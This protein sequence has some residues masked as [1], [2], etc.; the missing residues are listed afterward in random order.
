ALACLFLKLPLTTLG[1]S[2]HVSSVIFQSSERG[3]TTYDY[4]NGQLAVHRL[5]H[6]ANHPAGHR[7]ADGESLLLGPASRKPYHT[8]DPRFRL[9]ALH[10]QYGY[11]QS[12][13][14]RGDSAC[15]R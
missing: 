10:P 9:A 2:L 13:R 7:P 1:I 6:P 5:R 12:I 11:S 8:P 3:E 4:K 15:R 14:T